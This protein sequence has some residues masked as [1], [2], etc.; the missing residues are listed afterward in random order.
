MIENIT[1]NKLKLEKKLKKSLMVWYEKIIKETASQIEKGG[2]YS[3]MLSVE[4]KEDLKNIL[5]EHYVRAVEVNMPKGMD[6]SKNDYVKKLYKEIIEEIESV[7]F[8]RGESS[9]D[10]LFN[11]ADKRTKRIALLALTLLGKESEDVISNV[12]LARTYTNMAR[13][14]FDKKSKTDAITET[15]WVSEKT[16]VKA[17]KK[18]SRGLGLVAGS[19]VMIAN[20]GGDVIRNIETVRELGKFSRRESIKDLIEDFEELIAEEDLALGVGMVESFGNFFKRWNTMGDDRVRP[21]H[22]FVDQTVISID[23]NFEV[24]AYEMYEPSDD[25][26]GAG[27]EEIA[28]CRCYLTYE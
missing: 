14:R 1:L 23:E 7:I 22:A 8:T 16:R 19:T 15:N 10:F 26:F 6:K 25:S 21:T 4:H 24:G 3:V 12:E 11:T 28:N 5:R 27:A 2:A 13:Q 20:E 9:V 17:E 18:V